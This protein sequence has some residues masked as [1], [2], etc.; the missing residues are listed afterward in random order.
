MTITSNQILSVSESYLTSKKLDKDTNLEVYAN[1]TSSEITKI[2][3]QS[4]K[5]FGVRQV[6]F[7][8]DNKNKK[9]YVADAFLT[10]HYT[11][12]KLIGLNLPE[13]SPDYFVGI[14]NVKGGKPIMLEDNEIVWTCLG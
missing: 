3:D 13:T 5:T 11:I 8:V 6:R 7:V 9:V 1:P 14:A 12:L 4:N 10:L 2:T